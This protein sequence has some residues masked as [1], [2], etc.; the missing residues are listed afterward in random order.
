VRRQRVDAGLEMRAGRVPRVKHLP[1]ALILVVV[2]SAL[3]AAA[4]ALAAETA[5]AGSQATTATIYSPYSA[6]GTSLLHTHSRR[7]HCSSSSES[8]LHSDAWRCATGNELAD[9]CFSTSAAA[10][11]VVCPEAPWKD[12]GIE[13]RLTKPL[14]HAETG[15][16]APSLRSRPW[17]L[18]LYD[19][20]RCVYATG[21]T[22]VV[23]GQRLNYFCG[24][25][26]HTGL[27]GL[28]NRRSEPWTILTAPF[29][30][31]HLAQRTAIRH[32]WM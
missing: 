7:G 22:N 6:S 15:R 9:P 21:A 12:T 8:A 26:S 18:E 10:A 29:A 23:E 30:A 28:P 19:G 13:I 25:A 14:P 3:A 31:K 1:V 4:T 5:L 2:A 20:Q 17:A 32:A 24:A 11:T 27:W 16:G